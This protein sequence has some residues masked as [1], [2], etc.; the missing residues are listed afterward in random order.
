MSTHAFRLLRVSAA[1]GGLIAVAA[2]ASAQGITGNKQGQGGSVV[3]GAAGTQGS[4]GDS[5]L[6]HCAQPMGAVAVVEPQDFIL[7]ALRGYGLQSPVSLIRLMIQ[8]SNCFIVVERGAGMQNA[9]QERALQ[10]SG[11]LRSNSNMG[12]GQIVTADFI[13]TPQVI[14]SEGNA[15]GVGAAVGGLL[16]RR[17]AAIAGGL[18]F[19]EAQTS[20]L[21][22]DARSTVQVAAAEGSTR[23][24]DLRLGAGLW[25]GGLGAAAG[26]YGNTNEG[27]I[28]AA[29]LMDNYN[30]IVGVV[31]GDPALQRSVGSLAQ[32]AAAGG[33]TSAGAAF[34]EGDVIGP[35][36]AGVK[37]LATPADD[38]KA[39]G[40]LARTDELVVIG[41]EQ[42]GFINVQGSTA[43]GWVKI[44]LV[45]KR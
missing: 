35:K 32:E 26:G 31:R 22:A 12:G 17:A 19:K 23:K 15:G 40:T 13:L 1:I 45:S 36:I 14:F 43:A 18:K 42:N 6:Q 28:I 29:A 30:N 2:V 16:G 9:L 34:N 24:A 20:M 3:Q 33:Q 8:Q 39:V 11:E 5:G 41:G 4:T 37:L 27:K 44:V 7:Q 25:G 21:L 38:G 10:N